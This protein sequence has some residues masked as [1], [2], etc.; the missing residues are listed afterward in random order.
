MPNTPIYGLPY[1]ALTEPPDGPAQFEALAEAVESELAR[2]DGNVSA[3]TTVTDKFATVVLVTTTQNTSGTTTSTSFTPTLTGGTT[4]SFTFVA[5]PSGI[6]IVHNTTN[7]SN[8]LTSGVLMSFEIRIGAV[9]GSG[10]VFQAADDQNTNQSSGVAGVGN[11]ATVSTPV[12]GLTA[13]ATY[14]IRQMFRVS[15]GTGTFISKRLTVVP[16]FF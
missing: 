7:L 10:T 12:T 16:V 5:P 3:V 14:N 2:I 11:R 8:T 15:A 6:I 13:G 9:I 1:P 4:C